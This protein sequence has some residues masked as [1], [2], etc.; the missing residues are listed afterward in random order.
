MA[1][2]PC[3]ATFACPT[4][5]RPLHAT[6]CNTDFSEPFEKRKVECEWLQD[7]WIGIT[8]MQVSAMSMGG[9]CVRLAEGANQGTLALNA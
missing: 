3:T 9:L 5:L 1:A 8:S 7:K 6:C 4:G 2:V